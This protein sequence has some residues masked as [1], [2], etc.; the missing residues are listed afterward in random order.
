MA[1]DEMIS[2][3]RGPGPLQGRID[4]SRL[5][6]VGHSAGGDESTRLASRTDV[7]SW[8]ALSAGIEPSTSIPAGL[9]DPDKAALWMVGA[10]DHVVAPQSVRDAFTYTAGPAKLVVLPGGGHIN[11]MSD[12]CEIAKDQGGIIGLARKA[13]LPIPDFLAVLATDGC[14]SPPAAPSAQE[15][16]IVRQF[17][18]A[19]LRYRSGLDKTPVGLGSDVVNHLGPIVAEYHHNP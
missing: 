10:Q 5:F 7:Q 1:V 12:I 2:L 6:P 13:G 15:W 17:V 4:T 3:D 16:P 11:D 19:E 8:I 9:K 14:T 18:T